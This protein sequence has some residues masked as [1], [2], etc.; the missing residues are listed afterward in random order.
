MAV[1]GS[2][3]GC[4]AVCSPEMGMRVVLKRPVMQL[5]A[6]RR[7]MSFALKKP[8]NQFIAMTVG[9]ACF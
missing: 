1:F 3:K 4:F 2:E 8:V 5:V 6:I 7:G 9:C